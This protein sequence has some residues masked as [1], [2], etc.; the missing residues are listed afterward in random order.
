MIDRR[1]NER[2]LTLIGGG[3]VGGL[4]ADTGAA[5]RGVRVELFE[6]RRRVGGRAW[7]TDGE[8][9]ANCGPHVIYADGPVVPARATESRRPVPSAATRVHPGVPLRRRVHRLAALRTARSLVT[10]R[11]ESLLDTAIPDWR[12]RVMWRRPAVAT[13]QSGAVDLRVSPGVSVRPSAAAMTSGSSTTWSRPTACRRMCRSTRSR[14][15]R[16]MASRRRQISV[17]STGRAGSA[18]RG[19][20]R[21]HSGR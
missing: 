21:R 15:R 11:I 5:E 17:R 18:A 4:T 19:G 14:S 8:F 3:G 12:Q 6:R 10:L 7:T 13:H 20:N 9:K 16:D 1:F 2:R